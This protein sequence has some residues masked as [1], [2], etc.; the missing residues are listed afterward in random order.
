MHQL[1]FC[2]SLFAALGRPGGQ[3]VALQ[4]QLNVRLENR[5]LARTGFVKGLNRFNA[6][7][8]LPDR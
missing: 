1:S 4:D 5:L 2:L 6:G 8:N 7:L 3:A